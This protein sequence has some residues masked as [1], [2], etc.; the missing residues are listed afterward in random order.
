M[1]PLSAHETTALDELFDAFS[2]ANRR[3]VL[4]Q[5]Y[6]QTQGGVPEVPV[7]ELT[8]QGEERGPGA[9]RLRHSDLPKLDAAGFIDWERN[10]H[11]VRPGRRFGDVVSLIEV[12]ASHRD[13][14]PSNRA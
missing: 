4:T 5:L 7:A 11:V 8:G 12:L 9:T 10:R 13:E 6:D 3:H 14:L 2:D 1:E